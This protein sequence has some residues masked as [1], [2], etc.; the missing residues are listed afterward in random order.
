MKKTLCPGHDPIELHEHFGTKLCEDCM[1][2]FRHKY[3]ADEE[4]LMDF[5]F[6]QQLRLW[7]RK[8]KEKGYHK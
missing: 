1:I 3:K 2:L 6:S 7:K 4:R 5:V 8:L